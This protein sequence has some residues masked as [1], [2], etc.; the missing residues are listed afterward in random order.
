METDD[1]RE[2]G[3]QPS[4][5]SNTPLTQSTTDQSQWTE[6][7]EQIL[8]GP[9]EYIANQPGKDLRSQFISA[10]NMWLNVPGKSLEVI[11]GVIKMLHNASLL[12]D[13]VEDFSVLRRGIPVANSI[14]GIAQTIN[15]ANYVYFRALSE[16]ASLDN[17]ELLKIFTSELL[18][19]HRGQGLDLYW[20][21]SLIC[22]SECEYME[23]VDY[24]T[25][26]L[27]RLAVRLM[28]AQSQI[29]IDCSPLVTTI[30]Q[31]FQIL[32]DYLNLSSTG[33]YSALK[34]FCEDLTE[35]K[36]SFPMIHAIRA[37]P[38]NHV[39]IN[40]LRLRTTD[41]EVK[42]YAL[43]YIESV[44]SLKYSEDVIKGLK[45]KAE[46]LIDDIESQLGQESC[47]GE[48]A[49]AVRKLLKNL[50]VR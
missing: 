7:K 42:K 13:D 30:G 50:S 23:M 45:E 31:M 19:L 25:G 40:I 8:L 47:V 46:H 20:R 38:S 2:A 44:G 5:P 35:G 6:D 16:L 28:Q 21:D 41:Q 10:F 24:K 15:S 12:V 34:G 14:F 18:N 27:F 3:A 37:D 11:I 22:P 48:G 17:P 43:G 29:P 4:T 26:G 33:D 39:L 49:N 32:D 1:D 36:F 9:Y